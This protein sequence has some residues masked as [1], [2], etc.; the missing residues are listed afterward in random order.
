MISP[1]FPRISIVT[2][3]LNQ[4]D[5]IEATINSVLSQNYP[6]LEYIIID[7]KST[8]KTISI[9]DKY[10]SYFTFW[11]SEKD[12]GQSDALNKGFKIATGDICAYLNSD[13]LY[14]NNILWEVGEYFMKKKFAW[15]RSDVIYG[16]TIDTSNLFENR[17]STFEEFCAQQTI[18][19]QGVFWSHEAIS[20]PWFDINLRYTMDHKFFIN[21]FRNHGP[22][23]QLDIISSYFRFHSNAKTS[24]LESLLLK[25]RKKIGEEAAIIS[26]K[27]YIRSKIRNEVKRL[28]LKIE[29]NKILESM[30]KNDLIFKRIYLFFRMIKILLK[31]PYTFRDRVFLGFVLKSI[32]HIISN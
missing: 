5:Y 29:G 2:P 3:S 9:L 31:S 23:K 27:I 20:K 32:K 10:S 6:N 14:L 24:N 16:K 13:D 1:C 4:G 30:K 21:L 8:D 26:D 7:G 28:N 18:G 22:P 25:E 12:N 19:Q 17:I 11:V 15:I